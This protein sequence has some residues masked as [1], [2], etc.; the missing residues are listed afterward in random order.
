MQVYHGLLNPRYLGWQLMHN[1][2]LHIKMCLRIYSNASGH[3][4]YSGGSIINSNPYTCLI[5]ASRRWYMAYL[6]KSLYES[7]WQASWCFLQLLSTCKMK[8]HGPKVW[9]KAWLVACSICLCESS[10]FLTAELVNKKLFVTQIYY[11]M[12]LQW[13]WYS[14]DVFVLVQIAGKFHLDMQ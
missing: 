12:C 14:R 7:C 5:F 3:G 6:Q 13:H 4:W 9:W 1:W 11:R 10:S 8:W 2:D